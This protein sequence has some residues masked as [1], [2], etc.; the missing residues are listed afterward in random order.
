M[1][2]LLLRRLRMNNKSAILSILLATTFL[3]PSVFASAPTKTTGAITY[4]TGTLNNHDFAVT[5]TNDDGSTVVSY[6][7]VNLTTDNLGS[8]YSL[9]DT[10]PEATTTYTAVTL[11]DGTT[12]YVVYNPT[13]PPTNTRQAAA[14][15]DLTG[16]FVG[17]TTDVLKEDA[18]DR[19][20]GAINNNQTIGNITGDFVLNKADYT[21][22]KSK[23]MLQIS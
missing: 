2:K 10:E 12:K 21:P 6:Y 22:N 20:G 3:T 23:I 8:S 18:T 11:P 17:L 9:S 4:S 1:Y 7:K 19:F 13:T 5:T 16:D 14:T 15:G